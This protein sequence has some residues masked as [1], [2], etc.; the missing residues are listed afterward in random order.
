MGRFDPSAGSGVRTILLEVMLTLREIDRMHMYVNLFSIHH[1]Y[2]ET[3]YMEYFNTSKSV[4]IIN[5]YADWS[6]VVGWY[7]VV[8]TRAD[9]LVD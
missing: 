1:F 3:L 7:L 4:N 9:G 8:A 2:L 6:D 5:Q